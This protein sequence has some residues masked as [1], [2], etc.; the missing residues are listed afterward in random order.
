MSKRE[1]YR[2]EAAEIEDE[3]AETRARLDDSLERL[4]DK[5]TP[6]S[7][8]DQ[9]IGRAQDSGFALADR[10]GHLFWRRPVPAALM[11]VG[12]SLFKSRS[13]LRSKYRETASRSSERI[14]S[15]AR[16]VRRRVHNL[17]ENME[18]ATRRGRDTLRAGREKLREV[19]EKLRHRGQDRD[20]ARDDG[21]D[22]EYDTNRDAFSNVGGK[23]REYTAKAKEKLH[24]AVDTARERARD[25]G[26]RARTRA[27]DLFD[28]QP[29]L[30]GALLLAAG[31]AIAAIIPASKQE[32][33][34]L[35]RPARRLRQQATRTVSEGLEKGTKAATAALE[36]AR[37]TLESETLGQDEGQ[38]RPSVH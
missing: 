38:E 26:T 9:A 11:S 4:F 2:R 32:R 16:T 37:E 27:D 29:L 33:K 10:V 28:R 7:L 19:G 24:H 20:A 12:M 21:V 3:I 23:G 34:T 35:A 36:S 8:L 17:E 14:S 30:T 5:L 31:A 6:A 22:Y 15:A 18:D 13:K 1:R 25:Y